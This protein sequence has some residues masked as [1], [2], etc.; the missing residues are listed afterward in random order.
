METNVCNKCGR[1][2]SDNKKLCHDCQNKKD[3]KKRVFGEFLTVLAA[4]IAI[5]VI[6]DFFGSD[7]KSNN[8]ER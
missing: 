8:E 7:D 6:Q 1:E 2:M 4:F 5:P 3:D